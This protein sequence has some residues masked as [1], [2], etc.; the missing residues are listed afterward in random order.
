M[1]KFSVIAPTVATATTITAYRYA[2]SDPFRKGSGLKGYL[3]QVIG[4]H[5]SGNGIYCST[6][7]AAHRCAA[8]YNSNGSSCVIYTA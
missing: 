4:F 7:E 8:D 3:V 2:F 5:L 6:F 1:P